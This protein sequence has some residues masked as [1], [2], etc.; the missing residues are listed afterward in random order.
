MK[1][2][3]FAY[4]FPIEEGLPP[5]NNPRHS[6]VPGKSRN[7]ISVISYLLLISLFLPYPVQGLEIKGIQVEGERAISQKEVKRALSLRE[8]ANYSPQEIADGVERILTEYKERGYLSVRVKME[9]TAD[10]VLSLNID[11]GD[12]TLIGKVEFDGQGFFTAQDLLPLLETRR[13]RRFS[14][15]MVRNDIERVIEF[16]ENQGFP[17]CEVGLS[18]WEMERDEVNLC[19]HI[20]EGPRVKIERIEIEGNKKTRDS[21]I[22]R[23]SGIRPGDYF[24]QRELDLAQ[25][26]LEMSGLFFKVDKPQIRI[27]EEPQKGEVILQVEKKANNQAEGILGYSASPRGEISGNLLLSLGNIGGTGRRAELRWKRLRPGD[28]VIG[29]AYREPFFFNLP[30]SLGGKVEQREKRGQFNQFSAS[31]SSDA[32][33]RERVG[34]GGNAR[35]ERVIWDDSSGSMR[36]YSLGTQIS[37]ET[38]DYPPNPRKGIFYRTSFEYGWRRDYLPGDD[39]PH[40]GWNTRITTDLELSLSPFS[41]Q[42]LSLRLHLAQIKGDQSA[43]PLPDQFTLGGGKTVRGYEEEAAHGS[44]VAWLNLEYRFLLGRLSRVYPFFDYGYF[45][46]PKGEDSSSGRMWGYGFGLSI[47]S[48]TGIMGLDIGWGRGAS[49]GQAKLH[50]RLVNNF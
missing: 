33:L 34:W 15:G 36:R 40:K 6:A 23:V 29:F 22:K 24:D 46:F 28:S 16:Y 12:L 11:E 25:R 27:L 1:S 35:W 7:V 37:I 47:G 49:L 14:Q 17:F 48:K 41:R 13:G 2:A 30:F 32:P 3:R 45:S 31:L 43:I 9:V 21:F 26:R 42:T 4:K 19:F 5:A 8:R 38:R 50:L 44:L 20:M 18:N 10:G 39:G